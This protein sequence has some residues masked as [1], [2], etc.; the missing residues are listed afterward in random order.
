[1]AFKFM[2]LLGAMAQSQMTPSSEERI[3]NG[4][5]ASTEN[6]GG[7]LS[8]IMGKGQSLLN[9]AGQAVGGKDNLAAIGIGTLLGSL[10][11]KR[12]VIGGGIGG[13]M[14]GLLGMM[15]FKALKN[16]GQNVTPPATP[17]SPEVQGSE[18]DAKIL[19]TAMLDAAKADGNVD[20][21]ELN[22]ITN[23]MKQAGIGQE[24]LNYVIGQLQSPMSTDAI[25]SAV[26]GR[27]EL[28]A[29]VYS[30]SLMAIEVDTPAERSYLDQLAAAMG[31]L[32]EVARNIEHL[33]GMQKA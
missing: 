25:I 13:G 23:S 28:A 21:E 33:V 7:I 3:Q 9:S 20:Q 27:P 14:M 10:S 17:V 24:G 32:P 18:N 11:N 5:N 15:A 19:L 12:S 22:R 30:A 2:D 6:S 1:M 4:L 26:R 29:Q 16:S 31:L 8:D